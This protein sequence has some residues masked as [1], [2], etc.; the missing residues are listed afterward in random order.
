[1]TDFESIYEIAMRVMD[2]H[3]Q[4]GHVRLVCELFDMQVL[5]DLIADDELLRNAY[6]VYYLGQRAEPAAGLRHVEMTP[7]F[8]TMGQLE[9]FCKRHIERFRDIAQQMDA[10]DH[11]PTPDATGWEL[12]Q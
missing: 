2:E 9:A 6:G 8:R 7:S 5:T 4:Y 10:D 1:M 3:E 11:I 12:P